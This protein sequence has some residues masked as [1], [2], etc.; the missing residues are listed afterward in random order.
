MCDTI[1]LHYNLYQHVGISF[2]LFFS[3]S[4]FVFSNEVIGIALD[5]NVLLL[6]D[7]KIQLGW[8]ACYMQTHIPSV[9]Q[10]E[11]GI[12]FS[13]SPEN[14]TFYS[15]NTVFNSLACKRCFN[16]SSCCFTTASGLEYGSESLQ[17]Y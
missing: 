11:D 16:T 1:K 17:Y 2:S 13:F 7:S 10:G 15:E 4:L 8:R 12:Y 9:V 3:L 5:E 14:L 6:C